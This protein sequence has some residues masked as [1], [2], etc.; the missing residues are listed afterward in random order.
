MWEIKQRGSK[1]AFGKIIQLADKI[2]V[3]QERKEH[4]TV[5]L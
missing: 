4:E 3:V 2:N 1:K 5:T